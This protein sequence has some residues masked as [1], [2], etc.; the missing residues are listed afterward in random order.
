LIQNQFTSARN[1]PFGSAL[2]FLLLIVV[3]L[4]MLVRLALTRSEAAR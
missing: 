2:S 3:L 1:W 4:G